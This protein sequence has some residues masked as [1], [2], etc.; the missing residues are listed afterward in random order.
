MSPPGGGRRCTTASKTSGTPTPVFALTASAFS[1]DVRAGLEAGC[2]AHVSKP[3]KKDVLL[4]ALGEAASAKLGPS[5]TPAR[6]A[7]S[8]PV[9]E[10]SAEL[11]E[12]VPGFLANKRRDLLLLRA[13][14]EGG[15]YAG[16]QRLGH[17]LKGEGG[18]YGFDTISELGAG[19]EQA[20]RQN[21]A[22]AL[23]ELIASLSRYLDGVSVV[24]R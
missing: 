11:K 12:I 16:L 23:E 8:A 7:D 1:D 22:R 15:D 21:D 4:R 9:I 17:A 24:Y 6:P 18:S 19:L 13:A 20:A 5:P 14:L 10:V 2:D 3:V